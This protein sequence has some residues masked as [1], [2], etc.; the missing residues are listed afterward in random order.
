MSG[1]EKN[2]LFLFKAIYGDNFQLS[3]EQKSVMTDTLL[4]KRTAQII[5]KVNSSKARGI[6]SV[7]FA[8]GNDR[9]IELMKINF[10]PFDHS[11]NAFVDN[12]CDN[13]LT[14]IKTQQSSV[15]IDTISVYAD[16]DKIKNIKGLRKKLES[17]KSPDNSL[18]TSRLFIENDSLW[19][20]GIYDTDKAGE[21]L[22]LGYKFINKKFKPALV[23]VIKKGG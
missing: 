17:I 15:L 6:V 9:K 12:L 2:Y 21:R 10:V 1:Q 5:C 18:F 8:I 20:V 14:M 19:V 23:E 7:T 16:S 13:E 3:G 22:L 11:Q 4:H